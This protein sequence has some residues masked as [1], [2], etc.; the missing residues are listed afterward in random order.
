MFDMRFGLP[1][2]QIRYHY[3]LTVSLWDRVRKGQTIAIPIFPINLDKSIW[4]DDS[5]D[6]KLVSFFLFNCDSPAFF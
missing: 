3:S 6:F 4:G 5:M 1:L 2:T